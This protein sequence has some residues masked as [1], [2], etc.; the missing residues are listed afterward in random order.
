MAHLALVPPPGAAPAASPRKR[1]GPS[2]AL[3]LTAEEARV[4][5]VSIRGLVKSRYGTIAKLARALKVHPNVLTHKGHPAAAL[6]VAL[7]RETGVPLEVLL[8]GKL[9]AVA[10]SSPAPAGGG[11]A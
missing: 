4:L 9:A 8:R 7:W 10:S 11:A 3:S 6:A 5:R 1:R 2:P